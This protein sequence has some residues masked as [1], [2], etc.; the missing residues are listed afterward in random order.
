MTRA[1]ASR[2]GSS[3]GAA[4]GPLRVGTRR[5]TRSID[6]WSGR[7]G[8]DVRRDDY[9][10]RPPEALPKGSAL[11]P[12][13]I[14][15]RLGDADADTDRTAK[16]IAAGTQALG[17]EGIPHR[18]CS[19]LRRRRGDIRPGGPRWKLT[20]SHGVAA[21]RTDRAM[22]A[23]AGPFGLSE[24]ALEPRQ[25][26][27]FTTCSTDRPVSARRSEVKSAIP[28]LDRCMV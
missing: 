26:V 2:N 21:H 25:A 11:A 14:V 13:P 7:A 20:G 9:C 24:A 1:K 27:G 19:G 8:A 23:M 12:K 22:N 6:T 3:L 10:P 18:R 28:A 17:W 15:L 4:L 16:R 5:S